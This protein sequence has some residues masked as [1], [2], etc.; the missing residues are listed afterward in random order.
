MSPVSA[1]EVDH[2]KKLIR[3]VPDFPKKG[4]LFYDITTLL[5]DKKGLAMLI[6]KLSEHYI[7]QDIDLVLGREARGFIFAPALAYRLNAGF[8]PVR[9]PGKLPA[10]C[11]SYDYALEYGSNTFQ[12]HKDAIK[13]S[14]EGVSLAHFFRA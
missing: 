10:E 4:I 11:V 13:K 8:I 6:D 2:L 9:K 7:A 3:E 14:Q 12:V 5:K 1:A